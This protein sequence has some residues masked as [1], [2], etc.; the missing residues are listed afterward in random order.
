M[1]GVAH[2]VVGIAVLAESADR[3]EG[4]MAAGRMCEV[5]SCAPDAL[6]DTERD[7]HRL[8]PSWSLV[9][10]QACT[11]SV[12]A[13]AYHMALKAAGVGMALADA[14]TAAGPHKASVN[15]QADLTSQNLQWI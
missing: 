13:V 10:I 11:A 15:W 2:A 1:V 7:I 4:R 12:V 5:N 6:P 8:S 9:C 14:G 3:L